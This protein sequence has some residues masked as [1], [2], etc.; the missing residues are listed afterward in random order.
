MED[1][2]LDA[3]RNIAATWEGPCHANIVK[4]GDGRDCIIVDGRDA[5]AASQH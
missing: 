4:T 2:F 5:L 3:D 1:V